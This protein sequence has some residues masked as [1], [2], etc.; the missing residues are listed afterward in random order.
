[1]EPISSTH[2][3]NGQGGIPLK[4][5][6]LFEKAKQMPCKLKGSDGGLAGTEAP[7]FSFGTNNGTIES[8]FKSS[9]IMDLDF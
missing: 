5:A 3:K 4:F 2:K 6:S 8:R 1:V 9:A 7:L